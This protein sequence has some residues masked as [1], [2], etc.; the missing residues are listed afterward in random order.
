MFGIPPTTLNDNLKQ[1]IGD[2]CP[3]V[4]APALE[5]DIALTYVTLPYETMAIPQFK[6]NLSTSAKSRWG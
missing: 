1:N 6:G 2:G 5:R 4:L 3:T